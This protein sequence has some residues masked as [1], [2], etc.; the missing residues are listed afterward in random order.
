MPSRAS[1][2][3]C[4]LLAVLAA[5]CGRQDAPLAPVNGRVFYRGEPLAGGTI[6][7]TPDPA[8][9]GSGPL[10]CGEV[11]PD[12]RYV[13]RTGGRPGAVAGWHRI[14]VAA[15]PPPGGGPDALALPPRYSDPEQSGERREVQPDRVNT[16]DL[17]LE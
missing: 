5:G 4:G 14:T 12:G 6:V 7:F 16:L 17:H 1:L 15:T 13:L 10:A 8:R 9:G 2:A 3:W 11:G